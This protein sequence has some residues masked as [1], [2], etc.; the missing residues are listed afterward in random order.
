MRQCLWPLLTLLSITAAAAAQIAPAA[1]VT[2]SPATQPSKAAGSSAR[3][4]TAPAPGPDATVLQAGTQLV[5]VDVVVEDR[6]GHPV[7]GL[8]AQ[9]FAVT[10]NKVAQAIHTFDEHTPLSPS[11]QPV[12]IPKLPPGT[13]TNYTPVPPNGA[14]NILLLD[15]LNTPM[16]DQSF[17][18]YQLQQYVKHANPGTRIAIFGLTS[19]LILLQGFTSSP[20][21]LKNAVDHKL[22][23][24]ASSLLDDPTGSGADTESLSDEMTELAGDNPSLAQA[25][26][27]VADFEAQTQAFQMQ[28]RLQYTLDAFN[29]LGHYLASFP[30]RKNVIWFS[31]SFP[32][33]ILPD[34]TLQD[35]FSVVQVNEDEFRETTGLLTKAQVAVYPIDARGL[36]TQPMFDA[37]NS[38]RGYAGNPA[39]FSAA[40]AKFSTSQAQEHMTMEQMATDTG[41]HAFYNTNGLA[42][43]VAQAIQ[44]GSNYYTLTYVP[45]DH[46]QNGDYREIRVNLSGPDANRNLQLSYRHGYFADDPRHPGKDAAVAAIATAADR[47]PDQQHAAATYATAAMSRGAPAPEDL[48]F[49]VSVLPASNSTEATVA[50]GNV[51]D[52]HAP[53][54]G[55]FRRYNIDL[56][57]FAGDL[58]LKP[59]PNESH[60]GAVQLIAYL[61]D[62][63]GRLVNA[64][65]HSVSFNLPPD[66]YKKFLQSVF[67]MHLEVSAPL[68]RETY[69]RIGLHDLNSNRFG[70]V[71][72]P[73]LDVSRLRPAASVAPAGNSAGAALTTPSKSTSPAPGATPPR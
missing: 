31:G 3:Q 60:S 30:G 68:K 29:S 47:P 59:G 23:P 58:S 67:R 73:V 4:A 51:L 62:P 27:N 39:K 43:A 6:N 70:V 35:P 40:M 50:N 36:M 45:T 2:S 61:Y 56:V 12:A 13:F 20:D 33:D 16:K 7:H 25:A 8:K 32:I 42:E 11:A 65:G 71:E 57:S 26:A 10:E 15:A 24:R 66:D 55:P 17:V 28:L 46:R 37:A 14:L 41:G 63:D 64:A 34:A 5:V 9:D 52:P 22:L 49:K 21:T 19:R 48:L 53:L 18:R 38:G 54:K 1:P 44:A 72:V 69:L